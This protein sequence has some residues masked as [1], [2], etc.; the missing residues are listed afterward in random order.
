MATQS[1]ILAWTIPWT[2]ESCGLQSMGWQRVRH[3]CPT[4]QQAGGSVSSQLAGPGLTHCSFQGS[5]AFL[6]MSASF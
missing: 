5:L 2:Q 6:E 4:K 3:D 1:S